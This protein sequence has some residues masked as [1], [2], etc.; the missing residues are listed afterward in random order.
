MKSSA[1][2]RRFLPYFKKYVPILVLDLFCAALTTICDLVLPLIVR[3]I[4][5]R[6]SAQV[7]TLTVEFILRVGLL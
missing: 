7:M 1:L 2:I 5:G 6:A 4:T 3:D